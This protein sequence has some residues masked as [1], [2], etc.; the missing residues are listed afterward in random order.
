MTVSGLAP[1]RSYAFAVRTRDESAN[2]SA[3]SNSDSAIAGGS[4]SWV[5]VYL[6]LVVRDRPPYPKRPE[7]RPILN[8]DQDGDYVVSW[9]RAERAEEYFLE[10]SIAIDSFGGVE[11]YA[12]T[13]TS[14]E[15]SSRSPT[16][17]R[18]R[19]R[20]RN[21]W[22]FGPWSEPES[23]DVLWEL[24]PNGD[25][26][27]AGGPL[28][29]GVGYF[30]L[31]PEATDLRD[32]YY[33]DLPAAGSVELWLSDIGTRHDYDLYLRDSDLVYWGA[34][35]QTSASVEHIGPVELPEA[36]RYY[37]LVLNYKGTVETKSPY[38]L[39]VVYQQAQS[40]LEY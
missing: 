5:Y 8:A 38:N 29:S 3:L 1:G 11:V 6:P 36:G 18:Y 17:Y 32:F 34:S 12:G 9:K 37:I 30:G 2:A 14:V 40:R 26:E 39:R 10:E 23:T 33:F 7:L 21:V 4:V 15:L 19:V 20:A 27:T 22:G 28:V 16:R 31:F 24:E 13:D 25:H 35:D